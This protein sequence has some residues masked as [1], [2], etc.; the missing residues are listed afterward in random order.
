LPEILLVGAAEHPRMQV[1]VE[2]LM[3]VWQEAAAVAV[4]EVEEKR[5]RNLATGTVQ[6]AMTC[7]LHAMLPADAVGQQHL[8]PAEAECMVAVVVAWAVAW[9]AATVA[10]RVAMVV[11][12]AAAWEVAWVVAMALSQAMEVA[13]L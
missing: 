6:T 2:V 4:V 10:A 12:C 9:V 7:S 11:A 3:E 13:T 5:G 1:V 8:A